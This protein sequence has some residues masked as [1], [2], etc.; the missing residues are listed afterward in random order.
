M[1]I[2]PNQSMSSSNWRDHFF[3]EWRGIEGRDQTAAV[4]RQKLVMLIM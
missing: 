3:S 4:E 1:M 2:A